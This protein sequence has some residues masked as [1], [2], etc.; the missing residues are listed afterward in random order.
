[1]T[2]KATKSA[3]VIGGGLAGLSAAWYLQKAGWQVT[4]FEAN[5]KVGG[6]V[7][8][9]YK[10]NY[11]IDTGAS[12][13]AESYH[14][15]LEL[16][17]DLGLSKEI[18][19]CST[20]FE[21]LRDGQ[22]HSID[23]S[24]IV[25]SAFNSRLFSWLAKIKLLRL[26]AEVGLA[27]L[28]GQLDYSDM[29]KSSKLDNEN[30]YDY[31]RRALGNELADF[32][33]DPMVR[34]ML[35]AD[36]QHIS[37]VELFS[38]VANIFSTRLF[39]LKGGVNRLPKVLAQKLQVRLSTPVDSVRLQDRSVRVSFSD[40]NKPPEFAM[41][42]GC[43]VACPLQ[44][45]SKISL[46]HNKVFDQISQKL[47]Y[48]SA[49]TVSIGTSVKPNSDAFVISLPACDNPVIALIFMDHNKCE[50]RSPEDRFLI[51]V[52]WEAEASAKHL[53]Q[54]D[55]FIVEKTLGY[56][57]NIFPEI[58]GSI[59]MTH[60]KRWTRA[61]PK[62]R[63]GAYQ[64]IAKLVASIDSASPIQYA[65]DYLSAAGQNTA[66]EMGHRAAINLINQ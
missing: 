8:T 52:H 1:M 30:A 13:L 37:K 44:A 66:I 51:N 64:L 65:G 6:R 9:A 58:N 4:V 32:F 59:E 17:D 38:A 33:C 35:I 25:H 39:G 47:D 11:V 15:Y 63:P 14:S 43:I 36:A 18:V 54:G 41:F 53:A 26:F 24:R 55:D 61:L 42:D 16:I 48:T 56:V 19:P 29:A 57:L 23:L 22:R 7:E 28:R 62:T 60:V 20:V 12:A 2:S 45:A 10:E 49:I 46:G 34:V 27:R 50:D 3:A 31:A 21:I 5:N 40:G